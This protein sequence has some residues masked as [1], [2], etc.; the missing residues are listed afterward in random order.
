MANSNQSRTV[1]YL[2][3]FPRYRDENVGNLRL[4]PFLPTL[5]LCL[6]PLHGLFSCDLP[7]SQ[8]TSLCVSDGERRG[9][10]F[11]CLD[12]LLA[13]D[14]HPDPEGRLRM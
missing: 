9:I 1:A 4:S 8:K 10:M 6:Y 12:I 7:E 3:P 13:C 14:G 11:I 5:V 2:T